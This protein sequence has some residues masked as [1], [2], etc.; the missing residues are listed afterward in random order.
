M[1]AACVLP[2]ITYT[3]SGGGV[4]GFDITVTANVCVGTL[5]A[6]IPSYC[7]S[8]YPL[9]AFDI[10]PSQ[11]G[12]TKSAVATLVGAVPPLTKLKF[13]MKIRM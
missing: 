9:P 12:M 7:P 10:F 11:P 3:L 2:S 5:Y 6:L 4:P 8:V 1:I 13:T